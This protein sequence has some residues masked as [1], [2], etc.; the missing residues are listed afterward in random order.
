M[1]ELS[2]SPYFAHMSFLNDTEQFHFPVNPSS[3][4]VNESGQGKTYNVPGI[5]EINVIGSKSLSEISF[6]GLFPA[7]R[8][9]FANRTVKVINDE[10]KVIWH[11][12]VY[13]IGFINKWMNAKHPIRFILSS[14]TYN[15]N[16]AASI[17]SFTWNEVVGGSGDIEYSIKLKQY[18]F[19]RARK[20]KSVESGGIPRAVEKLQP[21]SYKMVAGDSL[22]SIAKKE[23]GNGARWIEIQKL[24]GISDAEIKRLP[25]GK[26]LKLP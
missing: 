24:N 13:Y 8:Y 15:I 17:E 19:Y 5:G 25:I 2:G 10:V 21:Q 23:L 3:L 20:L 18:M 7:Q 22:W 11:D 12:P 6:S 16:T 9:P 14:D 26:V 1:H 4:E